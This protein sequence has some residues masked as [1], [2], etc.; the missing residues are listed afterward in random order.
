L[1]RKARVAPQ[2]EAV[3]QIHRELEALGAGL[4]IEGVGPFGVSSNGAN[5]SSDEIRS[6]LLFHSDLRWFF[7]KEYAAINTNLRCA[8]LDYRQMFRFTA[9]KAPL[10]QSV[11]PPPEIGRLFNVYADRV[12][13]LNLPYLLADDAGVLWLSA[14]GRA[15]TLFVFDARTVTHR[16]LAGFAMVSGLTVECKLPV[17]DNRLEGLLAYHVYRMDRPQDGSA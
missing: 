17:T 3:L 12:H 13:L 10:G 1:N 4:W 2:G 14:D 7:G 11:L 8:A 9:F 5:I 15:G 6:A 16:K